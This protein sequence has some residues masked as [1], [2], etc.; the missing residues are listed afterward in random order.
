LQLPTLD[1]EFFDME[2]QIK[3]DR[4][5]LDRIEKKLPFHYEDSP[6]IFKEEISF[7]IVRVHYYMKLLEM[8]SK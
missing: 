6:T 5:I 7:L 3:K 1:L 2:E 8:R 4:V